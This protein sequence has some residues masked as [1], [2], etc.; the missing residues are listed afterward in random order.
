MVAVV[1]LEAGDPTGS[2]FFEAME[3]ELGLKLETI[4]RPGL[5]MMIDHLE[6]QPKEN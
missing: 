3:K 6:E 4:Q 1:G 2:N 5:V